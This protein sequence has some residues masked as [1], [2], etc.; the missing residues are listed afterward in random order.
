MKKE[1]TGKM[2]TMDLIK[3]MWPNNQAAV[4]SVIT[5]KH[6]KRVV[7]EITNLKE[8]ISCFFTKYPLNG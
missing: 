8:A 5:Q 3:H 6:K 1:L 7:F 2:L 4:I